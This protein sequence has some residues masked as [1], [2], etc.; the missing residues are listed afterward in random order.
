MSTVLVVF[1]TKNGSTREVAEVIANRLRETGADVVLEPARAC[2]DSVAERD[3]VVLGAPLYSGRWHRDAHRFLRRHR[4]DLHDV[5][6][7]IF[8]MGPRNATDD[9][10]ERSRTQ[11]DRAIA[12]HEWLGP[13]LVNVFGGVDPPKRTTKPRRDL[14]DWTVIDAWAKKVGELVTSGAPLSERRNRTTDPSS[15]T[16]D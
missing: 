8:G 14:R 2:R 3:L 5:P 15:T 13:D 10:W 6:I 1:A 7:T 4:R 9:A 16:R 12:K 11:L